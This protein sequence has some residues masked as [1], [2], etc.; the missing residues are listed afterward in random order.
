MNYTFVVHNFGPQAS[1]GRTYVR[2]TD[3]PTGVTLLTITATQNGWTCTN[4]GN[5]VGNTANKN[6]F[7]C[8]REDSLGVTQDYPTITVVA[9][10]EPTAPVGTLRNVACLS[11]P[12]D[13][14][15]NAVYNP[16][17][18]QYKINNCNPA[19]LTVVAPGTF[20]LTIQK[21][22][23]NNLTDGSLKDRNT[24]LEGNGEQN[25]LIIGQGAPLV[26]TYEIKNLGPVTATGLTTVEDTLP[27]GIT[28]SGSVQNQNGWAC[29]S[30]ANNN[31]SWSC[32]R[33]EDLA[34]G[35]TFPTIIVFAK[36]DAAILDGIYSNIATVRNPGD[37]NANNNTD[38]ANVKVVSSPNCSQLTASPSTS[39]NAPNT[40]VT[41]ACTAAGYTGLPANLEYK[42]I[43]GT[44][45]LGFTGTNTRLCNLPNANS[46]T[47]ETTCSVRDKTAPT[48]IFSGSLVG[49]CRSVIATTG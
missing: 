39:P 13:P 1:T 16:N 10:A 17:L 49:A 43:C 2:D 20:D 27:T 38:P 45:D 19:N 11:N 34:L 18:G 36:S 33:T 5:T 28:I 32:T 30:G 12:N 9:R 4:T 40:P 7:E 8:F 41:Y 47:L 6:G 21:K 48:V 42:I 44:S 22:V 26:Y 3:F 46:A 35:A 25:I 15:E 23:G 31:R 24:V 37:S 29:T 14:N